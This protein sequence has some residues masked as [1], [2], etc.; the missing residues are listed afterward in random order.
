MELKD[1]KDYTPKPGTE[2]MFHVALNEAINDEENRTYVDRWKICLYSKQDFENFCHR[3]G[4]RLGYFSYFEPKKDE[5][6][7]IYYPEQDDGNTIFSLKR[8]ANRI[9]LLFDPT[10]KPKKEKKETKE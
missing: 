1:F 6:G 7:E 4:S 2:N 9:V 5:K 8:N 3:D 10:A